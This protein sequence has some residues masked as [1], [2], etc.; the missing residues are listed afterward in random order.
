M[1]N[2]YFRT[3]LTLFFVILSLFGCATSDNPLLYKYA[4][5]NENFALIESK[6]ERSGFRNWTKFN[7]HAVDGRYPESDNGFGITVPTKVTVGEHT[8]QLRVITMI[9]EGFAPPT[10]LTFTASIKINL[11]ATKY[12]VNG[13]IIDNKFW[14]E[15]EEGIMVTP[16]IDMQLM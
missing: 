1:F 8:I 13:S 4:G 5:S 2:K 6:S 11:Q 16:K 3:P 15:T 7:L 12:R 9:A 14:L 10:V